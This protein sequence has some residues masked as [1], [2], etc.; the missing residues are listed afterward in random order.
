[1]ARFLRSGF[2][3]IELMVVVAIIGVLMAAGIIAFSNAQVTARDAK[4]KADID[5]ISKAFEQY[6][7]DHNGLYPPTTGSFVSYFPTNT[8]PRDPRFGIEY[9]YVIVSPTDYCICATLE[10][11]TAGNY[12]TNACTSPGSG[13][14]FCASKRQ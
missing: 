3:L 5:A 4:R 1:M 10:R 13:R 6:Y 11:V 9:S 7:A 8:R 12:T 14:F 2:T